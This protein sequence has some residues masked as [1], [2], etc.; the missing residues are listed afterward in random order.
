MSDWDGEEEGYTTETPNGWEITYTP[1]PRAYLID[2]VK[3]DASITEILRC[4]DKPA[5]TAWGQRV[6]IAA[7]LQ[8]HLMGITAPVLLQGKPDDM[9]FVEWA[10]KIG[11][12]YVKPHKLSWSNVRDEASTRGITVH[13]A[14]SYWA[15]TGSMPNP[16]E[17]PPHEQ[18]YVFALIAFLTDVKTLTPSGVELA[19]G[20]KQ[21]S[22]AG[23]Y[24][25]RGETSE[26]HRVVTKTYPKW[27]SKTV[28]IPPG[29]FLWDLKTSVD[30]F[31]EHSLQLGAYEM[32]SVESGYEPTD[33]RLIVQLGADGRYQCRRAHADGTD[34]LAV[35]LCWETLKKATEDLK[36][37]QE[38]LVS[39]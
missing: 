2:G 27:P 21:F 24:D 39:A 12:D 13:S 26:A 25:L 4:L 16:A 22:F 34:F 15:S 38:D 20:S 35:K 6:G 5:L 1:K 23:R 29:N 19:V 36:I 17:Y 31:P 18:G 33:A 7:T 9:D 32:A 30:V 8:L 10:R 37:R 28:V 11:D 3:A 14:F